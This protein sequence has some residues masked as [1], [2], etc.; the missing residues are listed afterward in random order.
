MSEE[1]QIR[2][3][4][5]R[6]Y[7]SKKQTEL[8]NYQ[9]WLSKELWNHMLSVCK[10][11]YNK[12]K[13]FPT[14]KELREL[15]KNK[16]LFSQVGQELADR[17]IDAVN[18][19]IKL[20]KK[21]GFPRFK[22]F[23]QMKSLVYPQFG[24]SLG[25]KLKVTPFDEI[26]IKKHREIKGEIKTLTIKRESSG[27]FY[28][29]FTVKEEKQQ[30]KINSGNAAGMDLGL[31]N[32]A[33][34]SD[35]TFIR[36]PH[37]LKKWEKRLAFFQ[38]KLSRKQKRGRNRIKARI[39]IAGIHE[40]IANVRNDFLHK[41]ANMI[42]SNYSLIALENL[43]IR[44][45]AMN[46]HGKNINDAAWSKFMNILSYKAE[47]AGSRVVFVN[48]KNTSKECSSCGNI[49]QK[50]LFERIHNCKNCG[51]SIDRDLNASINILNRS[52]NAQRIS[53]DLPDKANRATLG[54]RGSNACG[55]R[56]EVLP[57]K[58]EAH[59]FIHG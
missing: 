1:K 9:L 12:E 24:F 3:Y 5:F 45:M 50:S 37:H 14:K 18:R 6:L 55:D 27:K 43:E 44:D 4:K 59:E 30:L 54:S 42:L 2:A 51:L 36:N 48:P 16:G 38:R 57:M 19:K 47:S 22:N 41:T 40:K 20:K 26:S 34:L 7:P 21:A 49:V 56:T 29:I 31:M 28:A 17:L 52:R 11:K 39:K 8:I 53:R 46:N 33:V 25:E 58:Q 10:S 15:V 23:S 32:F 35:G 13:K